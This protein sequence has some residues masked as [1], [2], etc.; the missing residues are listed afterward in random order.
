[1]K[2]VDKQ[3]AT[4]EKNITKFMA[5]I[6]RYTMR[7]DNAI[8]KANKSGFNVSIDDFVVNERDV[9]IKSEKK[10]MF[11][12]HFDLFFS[13]AN[14]WES[15]LENIRN[16]N[17]EQRHLSAL[18]DKRDADKRAADEK[19]S[20]YDTELESIFNDKLSGF[21]IEWFNKM[22]SWHETHWMHIQSI[23]PE[24][25]RRVEKIK[26][27]IHHHIMHMLNHH[28]ALYKRLDNSKHACNQLL[29]SDAATMSQPDY[30]EMIHKNLVREWE[31][32]VQTLVEK[33]DALGINKKEMTFGKPDVTAKGFEIWIEDNT[34][35]RI[36]ARIIWCAEYSA[37]VSPHTRYIVTSKNK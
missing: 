19:A 5:N 32:C 33:C 6:E 28:P 23:V 2:Q 3:I 24:Q 30:M 36:Y 10:G 8:A 27:I 34:N 21:K 18:I 29:T 7:R 15:I 16:E 12:H 1:M 4:A 26:S 25:R 17:R 22:E 37:I 31:L 13:I 9:E 35:R 20:K 14:N 11:A